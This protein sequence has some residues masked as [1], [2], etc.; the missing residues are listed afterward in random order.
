MDS[1]IM[2][3]KTHYLYPEED[4]FK[5]WLELFEDGVVPMEIQHHDSLEPDNVRLSPKQT[6]AHIEKW[7]G[8]AEGWTPVAIMLSD[9]AQCLGGTAKVEE[10]RHINDDDQMFGSDGE[11]EYLFKFEPGKRG[12]QGGE[13]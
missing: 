8:V 5:P 11:K 9:L 13:L 4:W 6:D 7:W 10:L 2:D 12:W 3:G 1:N